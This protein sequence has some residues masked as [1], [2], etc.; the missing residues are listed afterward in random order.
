MA[1][2]TIKVIR[3]WIH[4]GNPDIETSF[5]AGAA[6]AYADP[7]RVRQI[8]RNLITN[9]QRHGRPPVTITGSMSEG[10]CVVTVTDRGKGI[11][12][13]A[14]MRLFEPYA[15]FGPADGQPLSVGLGLHVAR[16]LARLMDG[17]LTYRREDSETKYELTL[18]GPQAT[19]DPHD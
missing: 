14:E 16:R 4:A 11:P 13:D 15:R 12:K 17:D 8:L 19:T 9:A 2:E 10:R 7:L 18:P 6:P 1:E 3:P 5:T